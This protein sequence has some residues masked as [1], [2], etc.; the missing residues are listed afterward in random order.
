MFFSWIHSIIPILSIYQQVVRFFRIQWPHIEQKPILK[1]K[2][3]KILI[4]FNR[5][6]QVFV[7]FIAFWQNFSLNIQPALF[8][9]KHLDYDTCIPPDLIGQSLSKVLNFI[10]FYGTDLDELGITMGENYGINSVGHS[11][12]SSFFK[13][14]C[15]HIYVK[16]ISL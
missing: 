13:V 7:N 1:K 5:N 16:E 6:H 10:P 9:K 15:N 11:F 12:G 3:S 8:W 4:N 14:K 2:L